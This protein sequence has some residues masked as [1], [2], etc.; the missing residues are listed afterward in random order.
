MGIENV[1]GL[2]SGVN[3]CELNNRDVDA[4]VQELKVS[5][6]DWNL[7]NE[8][9][10][11]DYLKAVVGRVSETGLSER[12]SS[13]S[14][15]LKDIYGENICDAYE[16]IE[17][18]HDHIQID[19]ISDT[20]ESMENLRFDKWVQLSLE[21]RLNVLN[22]L[23]KKIA[24]IACRIPCPIYVDDQMASNNLG[25]YNMEFKDI[26]LNK[27][28][29]LSNNIADFKEVIDTVIHEGRHAYQD[30]NLNECEVHPRHSEVE[31]WRD[32]CGNGK[33]CYWGDTSSWLGQR[34]YEQQSIEIDARNFAADVIERLEKNGVF[35]A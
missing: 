30:Y 33:W 26:S 35:Y 22:E 23:E 34:L 14:E 12:Y 28:Y 10:R 29:V 3:L 1:E 27:D 19:Q 18:P 31:S 32:T 9:N 13:I 11:A 24:D 5:E 4:Y 7:M 21:N 17:A 2:I 8:E 25:G 16:A 20:I 6:Q 15:C